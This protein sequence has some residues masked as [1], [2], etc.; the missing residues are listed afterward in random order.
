MALRQ[1]AAESLTLNLD[2]LRE[3]TPVTHTHQRPSLPHHVDYDVVFTMKNLGVRINTAAEEGPGLKL[4]PYWHTQY[5]R[6]TPQLWPISAM[7]VQRA[8]VPQVPG[9]QSNRSQFVECTRDPV[10]TSRDIADIRQIIG[11]MCIV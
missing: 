3:L 9:K 2:S 7:F 8:H 6:G 4:S 5:S 1:G 11:L 10:N